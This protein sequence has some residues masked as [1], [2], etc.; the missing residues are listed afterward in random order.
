MF[1]LKYLIIKKAVIENSVKLIS[2]EKLKGIETIEQYDNLYWDLMARFK[3]DMI[4]YSNITIYDTECEAYFR[5]YD[6]CFIDRKLRQYRKNENI[7]PPE[8]RM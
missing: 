4:T 1:D 2:P 3:I 5:N 8:Y 6:S 7:T